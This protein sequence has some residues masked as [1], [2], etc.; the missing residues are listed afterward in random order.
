MAADVHA[1]A[2][3]ANGAGDAANALGGFQNNGV[4]VGAALQF[5]SGR[6]AGGT[7]TNDD[8]GFHGVVDRFC[9][10]DAPGI[11]LRAPAM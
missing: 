4:N 9:R 3:V 6:E 8:S 1:I 7:G 10:P 11:E 2:V 5:K